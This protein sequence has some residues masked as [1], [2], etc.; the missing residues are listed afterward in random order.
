M[1]LKRLFL[2]ISALACLAAPL[3]VTLSA[4]IV[5]EHAAESVPQP[6]RP[7]RIMVAI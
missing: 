3:T 5:T 6:P 1:R 7:R 4:N 2:A